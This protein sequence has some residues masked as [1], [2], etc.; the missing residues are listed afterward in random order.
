MIYDKFTMQVSFFLVFEVP[1]QDQ[2]EFLD[3]WKK[4]EINLKKTGSLMK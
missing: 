3:S 1:T 2:Q 4:L